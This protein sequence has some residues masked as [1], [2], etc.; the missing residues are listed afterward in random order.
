MNKRRMRSNLICNC[1]K[2]I[3]NANINAL[4]AKEDQRQDKSMLKLMLL[5]PKKIKGK[6]NY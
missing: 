1:N 6:I 3:K 2:K 5:M 4:D